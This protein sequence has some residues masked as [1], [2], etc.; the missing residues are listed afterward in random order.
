MFGILRC[1]I[2]Y[3]HP[4]HGTQAV[5]NYITEIY[6]LGCKQLAKYCNKLCK[7]YT[8]NETQ[9]LIVHSNYYAISRVIS[10]LG[11][12]HLA[13]YYNKLIRL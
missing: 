5:N 13:K 9:K 6:Y 3:Q 2:A 7:H 8:N 4:D 10:Y 12:K 11:T 1:D